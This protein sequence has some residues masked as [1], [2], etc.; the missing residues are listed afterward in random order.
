[1]KNR[2]DAEVVL[3]GFYAS[4]SKATENIKNG[5]VIVNGKVVVKP[6]AMVCKADQIFATPEKYVSRAAK[7]LEHALKVFDVCTKEKVAIDVGASTGGFSQVLLGSG[8]KQIFAVDVGTGQ[9]NPTIAADNRV[10]NLEQTN[11]LDL[12]NKI[13]KKAQ[14]IVSDVSFVSLTKLAPKFG[15]ATCPIIVLIKPQFEC[16]K[17]YARKHKG[18]VKEASVQEQCINNVVSEFKNYGYNL[19]A[20]DVSPIFGG[21]GNKEFVALFEK[22]VETKFIDIKKIVEKRPELE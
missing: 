8:V 5:S 11:F 9:L 13:I 7:K 17:E 3:R 16:G 1:M 21:D 4:R 2:L 6:S 14:I 12:D 18:I 22:K 10:I 19:T 20:L 15:R